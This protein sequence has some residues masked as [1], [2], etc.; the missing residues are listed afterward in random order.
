SNKKDEQIALQTATIEQQKK[1]Q[2]LSIGLISLFA[3]MLLGL[4]L[5]YNRNRKTNALLQNL[6]SDLAQKNQQNELL[7]KE[8]HHR[9]KNNLQ[10]ISSLLSLQSAHIENPEV[11]GAVEQSQ[12]RVQSMALIH[13]KL[14]QGENLAAVEMKEYLQILG[15][16]IVDSYGVNTDQIKIEYPME[17]IELDVDTAIPIGLIASELLTNSFKYAF[18]DNQ[19]GKIKVSLQRIG[20]KFRFLVSDNG[21][22]IS[23][24]TN[25]L[26]SGFGNQLIYLLVM[27]MDGKMKTQSEN[28]LVTE[29]EFSLV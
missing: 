12:N 2:W 24:N 21:I 13:Q 3:L 18:P 20:E 7:L 28:G 6:N 9:V 19:K 29:I 10:T 23:K 11:Q 27:Q 8:I 22:G 17:R 5:T 26:K 14:Y 4:F 15:E 16:T 1:I 25:T